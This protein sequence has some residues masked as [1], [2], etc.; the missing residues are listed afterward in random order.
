MIGTINQ[1]SIDRFNRWQAEFSQIGQRIVSEL[2]QAHQYEIAQRQRATTALQ[3]WAYQQQALYNQQQLL[4]ATTQPSTMNCHY[5]GN[6]L[7]CTQF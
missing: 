2:N 7:Q 3:M 4:H 1:R 6:M 5:I